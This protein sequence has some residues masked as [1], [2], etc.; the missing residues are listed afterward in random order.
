MVLCI[1]S[2]I[3]I[4]SFIDFPKSSIFSIQLFII[5]GIYIYCFLLVIEIKWQIFLFNVTINNKDFHKINCSI[6]P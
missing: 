5:Y 1:I 6:C 4:K 2:Y 3:D